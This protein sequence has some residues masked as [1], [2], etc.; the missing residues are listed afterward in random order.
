MYQDEE[1]DGNMYFTKNEI[2]VLTQYAENSQDGVILSLIFDGIS[3]NNVFIELRNTRLQDVD[4]DNMVIN[5]PELHDE[6]TGETLPMR[7]V[8]ISGETLKMIERAMDLMKN[9]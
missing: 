9:M 7:Q 8:P 3:H 1:K 6:E 5:V 2:D 4:Q